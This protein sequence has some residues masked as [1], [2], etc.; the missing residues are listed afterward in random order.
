[1]VDYAQ[2]AS[3][4]VIYE[5][6]IKCPT[7]SKP[8]EMA[9]LTWAANIERLGFVVGGDWTIGLRTAR[10]VLLVGSDGRR[11]NDIYTYRYK[12]TSWAI[13]QALRAWR[14]EMRL[15]VGAERHEWPYPLQVSAK[16]LPN[17]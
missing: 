2:E 11:I 7:P 8:E 13:E 9:D 1:M 6:T 14:T 5:V 10:V 4:M 16:T 17:P 15:L 3:M 12:D